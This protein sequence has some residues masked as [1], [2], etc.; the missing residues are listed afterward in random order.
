LGGIEAAEASAEDDDVV[1][2]LFIVAH[3]LSGIYKKSR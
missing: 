3:P 2:H 1:I